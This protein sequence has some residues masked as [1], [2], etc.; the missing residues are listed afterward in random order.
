MSAVF[1]FFWRLTAAVPKRLFR[2]HHQAYNPNTILHIRWNHESYTIDFNEGGKALGEI[3]LKELREVCKVLTGIPLG[4]LRL[5]YGEAT[6]KDDNAPL[7]CWGIKPGA[8]IVVHGIKPTKEDIEKST[9]NGDPE[10]YALILRIQGSLEKAQEF[11]AE[12]RS[13]YEAD[14]E[15]Y[16]A[17]NP[18]PFSPQEMP[19]PRKRLQDTHGMISEILLQSLLVLD[20]VTCPPEYEVARVKRREAVRETQKLLDIMDGINTRVKASDKRP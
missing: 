10:E 1:S 16:L 13:K 6:M 11:V 20:G 3:R 5:T 8:K 4:G 9:T 15:T 19:Q 17:S 18:A 12:H 7:S 14:V 2:V